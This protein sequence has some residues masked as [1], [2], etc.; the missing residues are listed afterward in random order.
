MKKLA[1]V[2]AGD[3][4]LLIAHH[5]KDSNY[6]LVGFFDDTKEGETIHGVK[7][8]GGLDKI[9]KSYEG[10]LFDE[11]I[12]A[13]GYKHMDFRALQFNRF[14][15]AIPFAK[16]VHSSSYV[17]T[18]VTIGEGSVILPGCTL[19]HNV[20]IGSNVLLNTGCTVAH[21]SE[22]L[23]H[24]FLSPGVTMAGFITVGAK[25]N[26]GINSTIIDNIK[27][28]DKVQTGGGAVV[29]ADINEPGLYIGIPAK[30]IK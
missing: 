29:V 18:S 23:N 7:L 15:G 4:G 6:D 11:L 3:L 21:D 24:S 10:K 13:I 27:V 5:S 17:D 20:I 28:C 26:I 2:G 8:L 12:I 14:Q 9:Q 19:D 16:I 25:C 30:R 1:I 22:V